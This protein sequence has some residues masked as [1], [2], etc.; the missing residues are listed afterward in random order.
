MVE[1]DT[2]VVCMVEVDMENERGPIFNL[3]SD[4]RFKCV[5][6]NTHHIYMVQRVRVHIN[7]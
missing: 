2:K 5:Y 4:R 1:V 7:S 3:S 6:L